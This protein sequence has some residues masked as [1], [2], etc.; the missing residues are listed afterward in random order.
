MI[1][2][3]GAK[4]VKGFNMSMTNI[5]RKNFMRQPAIEGKDFGLERGF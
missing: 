5:L 1:P 4:I 3:W 2:F